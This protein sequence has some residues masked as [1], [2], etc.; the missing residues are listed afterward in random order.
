MIAAT[1]YP[2]TVPA[3]IPLLVKPTALVLSL[4]GIHLA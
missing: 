3:A 2:N 4:N 1:T